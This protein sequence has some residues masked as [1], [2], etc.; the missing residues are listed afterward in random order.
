MPSPSGF[1]TQQGDASQV[2][3][4]KIKTLLDEIPPHLRRIKDE[5][6]DA[7][8]YADFT[9]PELVYLNKPEF[10][11]YL[12]TFKPRKTKVVNK[13]SLLKQEKVPVF[14]VSKLEKTE[15]YSEEAFR[16]MVKSCK[17]RTTNKQQ[18]DERR[19][20]HLSEQRTIPI[21]TFVVAKIS[22]QVYECLAEL[23]QKL[24]DHYYIQEQLHEKIMPKMGPSL[25]K[26]MIGAAISRKESA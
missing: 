16:R 13:E 2:G 6:N 19:I 1:G 26:M 7:K 24:E 14:R 3:R 12:K 10:P 11:N 21:G 17:M 4:A 8:P 5:D 22:Q 15:P 9:M 20:T 18:H 25:R 23:E